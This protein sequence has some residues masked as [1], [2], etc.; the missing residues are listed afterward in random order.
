MRVPTGVLRK[1]LP[2]IIRLQLVQMIIK[3]KNKNFNKSAFLLLE[4]SPGSEWIPL[5]HTDW[6]WVLLALGLAGWRWHH[7]AY[8]YPVSRDLLRSSEKW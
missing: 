1:R 5:V 3:Y 7:I 4:S 6:Q 8:T 2:I